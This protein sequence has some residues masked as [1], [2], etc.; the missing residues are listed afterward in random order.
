MTQALR[1]VVADDEPDMRDYFRK[2]LPRL[3]HSVVG[4]AENGLKLVE[5]CRTLQPDLVITDIKMTEMDGIEASLALYQERPVPVILVSAHHDPAMIKRAEA[6]HIMGYLVKP[7]RQSDLEPII[8]LAVWR[9]RM[10][11]ELRQAKEAA[12]RAYERIDHDVRLAAQFQ[13][14]L[15]P[16]KLPVVK[17]VRFAWEFCPCEQLAG[18]GLNVFWLDNQHLGLY[19]LDVSGHGVAAALLSVT[20]ARLLSPLLNQSALL[21]SPQGDHDEYWL[22]SPSEVA[23]QLNQWLLTNS[24]GEQYFTLVYGILDVRSLRL[25]YVSAGHPALLHAPA[26]GEP[27]FLRTPGF[28]IGCLP[29]ASYT[30]MDLQLAPGDRLF[31]YSDGIVETG[32]AAAAPFGPARLREAINGKGSNDVGA[33]CKRILEQVLAWSSNA[34]DDDLSILAVGI[35]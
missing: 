14:A 4:A 30:D 1:I 33:D 35:E 2:I 32:S 24:E 26:G 11:E 19:L 28:P 10:E 31:L 7:V 8:A 29:D 27:V 18:D 21:R 22:V 34:P 5:M 16:R 6:D 25:S 9:R 15:L 3:G 13:R 12:E 17:G 23:A 20:L